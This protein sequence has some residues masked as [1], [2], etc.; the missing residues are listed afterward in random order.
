MKTLNANLMVT[1][2]NAT[3]EYYQTYLGFEFAMWVDELKRMVMD[4][5]QKTILT[6]AMIK[7]GDVQIMLQRRD[8]MLEELP[9]LTNMP[10]GSTITL[11]IGTEDVAKL[12]EKIQGKVEILKDLHK[13][14]YGADEFVMRDLNGYIIYFA[15]AQND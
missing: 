12:F 14:F 5:S 13:T 1:D 4:T 3:I 6:W 11:Y 8:S 9:E 15:E 10:I 7:N 2:V